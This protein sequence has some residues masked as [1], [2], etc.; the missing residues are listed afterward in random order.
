[1]ALQDLRRNGMMT[2]LLDAL[3]RGEDIGHYG[4]LVFA[5]V[6]R[7]FS[8]ADTLVDLRAPLL[9]GRAQP[10]PRPRRV[11]LSLRAGALYGRQGDAVALS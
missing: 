5:M 2:H 6:A 3:E 1:M 10:S 4:R 11:S 9:V 7:H 8:D